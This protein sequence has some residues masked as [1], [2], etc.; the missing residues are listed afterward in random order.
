MPT[1][2]EYRLSAHLTLTELARRAG[3]DYRTVRRAEDGDP[4]QEVKAVQIAETL[5]KELQT[6][7]TVREL[8]LSRGLC[9]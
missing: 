3:L 7:L 8:S 2:K 1:L 4:I 5:S 9:K 6:T